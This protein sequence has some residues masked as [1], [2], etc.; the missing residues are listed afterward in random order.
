MRDN[1]LG[2]RYRVV[3]I[4]AVGGFGQT[5]ALDTHRPGNPKCVV[6]HLKPTSDNPSCLQNAA[7]VPV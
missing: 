4:L 6:K 3:N 1:L 7:S 2:R 5:Y